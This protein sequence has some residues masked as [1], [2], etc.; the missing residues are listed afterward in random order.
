MSQAPKHAHD[1]L[2]RS[3]TAHRVPNTQTMLRATSVAIVTSI[4][5]LHSVW[6]NN[7]NNYHHHLCYL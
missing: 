6:L 2:S 4:H 3:C 1:R 7:N 5:C